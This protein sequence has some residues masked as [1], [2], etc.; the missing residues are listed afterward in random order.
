MRRKLRSNW[1]FTV[2]R[3]GKPTCV[4]AQTM[5]ASIVIAA[6]ACSLAGCSGNSNTG[7][8]RAKEWLEMMPYSSRFGEHIEL[9]M[10]TQGEW[11]EEGQKIEEIEAAL[12]NLM[13]KNDSSVEL[14]QVAFAL[15]LVGS[16]ECVPVLIDAL[17]HNDFRVRKEAAA[18]LGLLGD[19][20]SVSSLCRAAAGDEDEN[21][22]A[23]AVNALGNIRTPEAIKCVEMA[24]RDESTFVVEIANRVIAEVNK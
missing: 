6:L 13:R 11:I 12:I 8:A 15:G 3:S 23:N 14:P 5:Y 21:V 22:R 10:L 18:S 4:P 19:E 1:P 9:P 20:R 17:S 16:S 2:T 24:L 7:D